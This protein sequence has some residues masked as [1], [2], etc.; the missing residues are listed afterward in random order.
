MNGSNARLL[1]RSALN[2]G[3]IQGYPTSQ[4]GGRNSGRF[5]DVGVDLS[6]QAWFGQSRSRPCPSGPYS[7][8]VTQ[9]SGIQADPHQQVEGSN[10]DKVNKYDNLTGMEGT[11]MYD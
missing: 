5:G 4:I 3:L 6:H 2:V 11:R 8:I 9:S 10:D 1:M 7:M